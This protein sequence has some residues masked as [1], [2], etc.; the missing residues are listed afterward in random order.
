MS[1]KIDCHLYDDGKREEWLQCIQMVNYLFGRLDNTRYNLVVSIASITLMVVL[2]GIY[3]LL[4]VKSTQ[5][6]RNIVSP[7]PGNLDKF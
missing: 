2:I 5:K 3:I 6:Y 1:Q 4:F 7:E